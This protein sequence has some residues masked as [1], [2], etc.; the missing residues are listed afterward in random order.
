MSALLG[1]SW[2]VRSRVLTRETLVITYTRDVL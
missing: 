1:G 2:V